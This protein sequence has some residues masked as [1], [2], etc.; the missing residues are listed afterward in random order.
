LS[1]R[2]TIGRDTKAAELGA[3]APIATLRER[4]ASGTIGPFEA[5]GARLFALSRIVLE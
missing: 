2:M 5:A 1:A 3:L 4:R